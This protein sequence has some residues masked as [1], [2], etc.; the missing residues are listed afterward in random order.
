MWLL[1]KGSAQQLV[2]KFMADTVQIEAYAYHG[3]LLL[4]LLLLPF[5]FADEQK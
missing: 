3:Q 2:N 4:L 1:R 5:E